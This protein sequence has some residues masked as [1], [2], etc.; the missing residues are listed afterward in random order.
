MIEKDD[1]VVNDRSLVPDRFKNATN[2]Q[3]PSWDGMISQLAAAWPT[4]AEWRQSR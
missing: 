1:A 2:W 3:S 4:Y